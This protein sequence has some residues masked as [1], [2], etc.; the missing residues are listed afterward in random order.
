MHAAWTSLRRLV[1]S[2]MLA[3]MLAFVLHGG[4]M[5]GPHLHAAGTAGCASH[6]DG[7]HH[8]HHADTA[9]SHHH[10]DAHHQGDAHHPGGEPHEGAEAC[11]GSACAVAIAS[12]APQAAGTP[13]AAPP[14]LLPE[15]AQG[16]GLGPDGLRR[17]PRT[18]D[19]A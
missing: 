10:G 5:A 3:A 2:A 1:A 17:P 19:I 14:V 7:G 16:S 4:A 6:A 11:C 12:P 18:P 9:G 8:H 13:V 15:P